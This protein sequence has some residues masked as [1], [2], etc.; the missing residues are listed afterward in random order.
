M[1]EPE[2]DQLT[3]D[4]GRRKTVGLDPTQHEIVVDIIRRRVSRAI[5]LG[6]WPSCDRADLEQ[7]LFLAA[8]QLLSGYCRS[9]GLFAAFVAVVVR[10]TLSNLLRK[11]RAARLGRYRKHY[12]IHDRAE[13]FGQIDKEFGRVEARLELAKLR[14]LMEPADQHL[15]DLLQKYSCAEIARQLGVPTSTVGAQ[16]R[17]LKKRVLKRVRQPNFED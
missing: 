11:H 3:V 9:R 15:L 17:A 8:M 14:L 4:R 7:Q 16:F 13:E 12:S 10:N 5:K 2:W 1:D 6:H